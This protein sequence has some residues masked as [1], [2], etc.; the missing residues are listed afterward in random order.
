MTTGKK[1]ALAAGG[2]VLAI[3]AYIYISRPVAL[4]AKVTSGTAYKAVP[5]S[6]IVQN[7]NRL[8]MRWKLE[9]VTDCVAS[10]DQPGSNWSG[11]LDALAKTPISNGAGYSYYVDAAPTT[12]G[13]YT[14]AVTCKA[15][16]NGEVITDSVTL[17]VEPQDLP[18]KE[19][20]GGGG[21]FGAGL[22]LPLLGTGFW[23]R[24][25]RAA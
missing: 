24:R 19:S 10:S 23:L 2:L 6:V 14:Y 13:T 17:Q 9:N 7:Y 3:V 1:L 20:K 16:D 11:P 4:V 15:A 21:A 25:R 5:G 12:V 18:L 22:L 8:D